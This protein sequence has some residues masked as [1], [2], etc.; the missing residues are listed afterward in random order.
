MIS[1]NKLRRYS[2][3]EIRELNSETMDPEGRSCAVCGR[4]TGIIQHGERPLCRSCASLEGFASALTESSETLYIVNGQTDG[5]L[6][7]PGLDGQ[8]WS[9]SVNCPQADNLIRQYTINKSDPASAK[10]VRI[11]LSRHQARAQDNGAPATFADM[12]NAS[13]G[14]RRLGVFRGDVDGLGVLFAKGFYRPE[15]ASPWKNCNMSYYSALSGALT[16]FFQRHLDSVLRE[17]TGSPLLAASA[18]GEQVTVVYAGGDD[19]FLVGA[20][21]DVLDSALRIQDE[22]RNYTGSSVTLS[23]GY[24]FFPEHTP[25]PVMADSTA[26]LEEDARL[27]MLAR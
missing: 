25:V 10:S 17:G 23:G 2:Y 16:W 26:D 27:A 11:S 5:G 13:Q 18:A 21:N 19:V 20:W 12:A 22:F 3:Q 7:V 14:I 9:L 8:D 6:P 15:D 1:V 4:S 24:S